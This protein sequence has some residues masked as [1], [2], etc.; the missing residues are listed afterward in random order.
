MTSDARRDSPHYSIPKHAADADAGTDDDD[1]FDA[2]IKKT[3]CYRHHIQVQECMFEH[4]DW[5]QCQQQLKLFKQCM[6]RYEA[7]KNAVK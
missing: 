2:R 3:G 5:R 4:R 6:D 1:P 7:S